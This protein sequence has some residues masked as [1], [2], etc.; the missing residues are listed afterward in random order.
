MKL[1]AIQDT[2]TKCYYLFT[3]DEKDIENAKNKF[4]AT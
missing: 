2:K 4:A 3:F 1:Y